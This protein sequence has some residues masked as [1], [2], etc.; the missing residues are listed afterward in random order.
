MISSLTC[1]L[2]TA[3][4]T[5]KEVDQALIIAVKFMVDFVTFFSNKTVTCIS[6][7]YVHTNLTSTIATTSRAYISPE[8]IQFRSYYVIFYF[9][10]AS[11]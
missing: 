11:I 5:A 10:G 9:P 4:S 8:W 2:L 3:C 6:N 1:I 7:L